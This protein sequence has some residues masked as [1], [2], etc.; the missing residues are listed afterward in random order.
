MTSV[1]TLVSSIAYACLLA[2]SVSSLALAAECSGTIRVL[3]QPRDGLTL[4]EG[5]KD[6]FAK[7]SGGAS[8]GIVNP[9][10]SPIG[11]VFFKSGSSAPNEGIGLTPS[12]SN[13]FAITDSLAAIIRP[14]LVPVKHHTSASLVASTEEMMSV[15]PE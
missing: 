8:F 11:S 14:C 12:I 1:K 4:L 10:N 6:E 3:A 9:K 7:L 2:S 15:L 5:Y 13:A